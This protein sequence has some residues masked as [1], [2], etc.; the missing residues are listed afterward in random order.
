MKFFTVIFS[1][2]IGIASHATEYYATSAAEANKLCAAAKAGDKVIMKNG[3]YTD[4]VIIF[5]NKNGLPGNPVTFIAE[6]PG[7]VFFE[8]NARLSFSGSYILVEGFTWQNGGRDLGM[9][10]VIEMKGDHSVFSNCAV[11]D[12][13]NRDFAIDNKWV[14]MYGTYN[15]VTNCL[16]KDKRN[17][18][19]TVTVWL[20]N[21]EAAHHT[22]S[23]N[24]FLNRINGPGADNGLES[25]RIGDSKTSFTDAHCVIAFNRFENCD[26]EIEIISNKSCHNSYFHNTFYNSNGGLT[27]RHG[28][29]CLVDGNVFDGGAKENSYGVRIIGEG[30]V[31]INNYFYNLKG[32]AKEQF[33]APLT[34]VNGLENTPING[35][36]QVRRAVVAG[37]IFVNNVTP[38][39]RLGARSSREGM[40]IPPDT[41]TIVKNIFF[42]DNCS[43]SEV[44]E[45]LS[46]AHHVTFN[47]NIVMGKC[48]SSPKKGFDKYPA[49][50]RD[51]FDWIKDKTGNIVSSAEIKEATEQELFAGADWIEPS[52]KVKLDKR[53]YTYTSSKEVGPAW[54]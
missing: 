3:T 21:G 54:Y 12:Y 48:L 7:K 19:A 13:N 2:L 10:S 23:S 6:H 15:T 20:K 53:K 50:K 14:S 33:R 47:A 34:I 27:L 28:N 52:I 46:A 30:H 43:G 24:Y 45:D 1:L 49:G 16:L 37:N 40:T 4:A 51:G 42:D 26:G 22:I 32:A 44:Y 31:V 38:D 36:Y 41:I 18:G 8:G 35:Y 11:I 5:E 17:L 39:V 9:K 25:I 29:N